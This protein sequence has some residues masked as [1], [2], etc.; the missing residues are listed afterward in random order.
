M[1]PGPPVQPS[2]RR[3]PRRQ[4]PRQQQLHRERDR[5]QQ[6]QEHR[7]PS[8]LLPRPRVNGPRALLVLLLLASSPLVLG[9]AQE[10]PPV[11]CQQAPVSHKNLWS[12]GDNTAAQ[13]LLWN[14]TIG[15]LTAIKGGL[16]DRQGL[17]I[18]G[19]LSMA[20]DEVRHDIFSHFGGS[21]VAISNKIEWTR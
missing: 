15:Y 6:R 12:G 17:A 3:S 18:S 11:Q 1:R 20:L 16:K 4:H 9:Q 14:L 10:S 7:R 19:A 13:P 2:R 8:H 5:K 21:P